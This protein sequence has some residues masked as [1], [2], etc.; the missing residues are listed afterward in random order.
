MRAASSTAP[1]AMATLRDTSSLRDA[2]KRFAGGGLGKNI[3][4][5]GFAKRLLDGFEGVI[6]LLVERAEADP[7]R[8]EAQRTLFNPL[9]GLDGVN[10]I[11]YGDRGC[12]PS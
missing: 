9:D 7:V 2:A 11:E 4:Q 6:E 10:H 12:G 8:Y 1:R 3:G 5:R